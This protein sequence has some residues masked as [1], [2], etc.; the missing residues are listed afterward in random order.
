MELEYLIPKT[1]ILKKKNL[2][3][4]ATLILIKPNRRYITILLT[5]I[6]RLL[7]NL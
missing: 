4:K 3:A 6:N 2:F 5:N 7:S 1:K